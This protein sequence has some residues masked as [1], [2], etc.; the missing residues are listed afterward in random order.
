MR[1]NFYIYFTAFF[2]GMSVMAVE[3]SATRLLAPTFGTSSIIWTIVIGLI[4]ISLSIGNILGGRSADKHNSMDRLYALIWAAAIYI[5]LIPFVGK[6]IVILS[7]TIFMW[8]SPNNL[9]VSGSMFSC[10]VIF[11][12]P[13]VILGM[14]TPYLVKLGITDMKNSGKTAG[15]IYALSTIGSI[16]GTFIP[17]FITIPL[18]G[19]S[20]TFLVF[21]LILNLI[22]LY[23]FASKRIRL[24]KSIISAFLILILT[25]IPFHDSYAFWKQ[26]IVYEGES[27]YNYLQ[28]SE[29]PQSVILSTNVAFGVQ[30][31]YKKNGNLTGL[32][33][34]YALMAPFFIKD[35]NFNSKK[36]VLILGLGTG[37][38][39]KQLKRFFPNTNI[40]G[41][42]IDPKI[43]DL[44]KKYFQLKDNE[45]NIYIN[46]GRTY[47]NTCSDKKYDL[48]MVDAYHDITIPFHMST[49]EFFSKVKEHLNAGGALVVNINIRSKKT[50]EINDYLCETIKSQMAKV[51]KCELE[52]STNTIVFASDD[53]NS[54]NNYITNISEI[55]NDNP[56]I[57]VSR[58]V[59][60][61][62]K[63][64]VKSDLVFTDDVAPVE[65]MGQKV[66]DEIVANELEGFKKE[67]N[68]GKGFWENLKDLIR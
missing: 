47:L 24:R 36:D 21:S 58:Y 11:S 63:E 65:I 9:V 30:S 60:N 52:N 46:D 13:L 2:S 44:S 37:T 56:L 40:D 7:V 18:I 41:V 43:V 48:I 22:C 19:T 32:Y 49:K 3:L 27:M 64:I 35:T 55:S 5:A 68:S 67:L 29:T 33:Y 1:K 6:Y 28:V 59:K 10:L 4:M 15:E 50:T 14:V 31:I 57:N 54:L 26:N 23:Y 51:Y 17:T 8:I 12:V 16:I 53:N 20:K 42:E 25:V 34:D 39:A 61:N 38:Y 62:S 45:A 66:L